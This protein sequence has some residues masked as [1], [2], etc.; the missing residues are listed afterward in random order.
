MSA[1]RGRQT[2]W[3][4]EFDSPDL[5]DLRCLFFLVCREMQG[6][7]RPSN[8]RWWFAEVAHIARHGGPLRAD[9][10]RTSNRRNSDL[11]YAAKSDRYN[12]Q[13]DLAD[14]RC[15]FVSVYRPSN[16]P[17]ATSRGG[18]LE[19][20]GPRIKMVGIKFAS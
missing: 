8:N 17:V 12:L 5:F 15:C 2:W 3:I 16:Q 1:I 20:K 18:K 4:T 10:W 7:T 13:A 11:R 6:R 19:E 9:D 14:R